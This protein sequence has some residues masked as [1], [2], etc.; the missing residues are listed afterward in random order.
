M[1]NVL[2]TLGNLDALLFE[3]FEDNEVML[4]L[5]SPTFK[6][7][8]AKVIDKFISDIEKLGFSPNVLPLFNGMYYY[9]IKNWIET[10]GTENVLILSTE[11]LLQN[12]YKTMKEFES[13]FNL[14]DYF[15]EKMF[16]KAYGGE[17]YC[18]DSHEAAAPYT[19]GLNGNINTNVRRKI[20]K[21]MKAVYTLMVY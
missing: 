15:T 5:D 21:I 20:K 1:S 13:F 14:E 4:N 10:F 7:Y 11:N 17:F 19:K 6:A 12:P 9:Y 16:K 18:I 3:N 2:K 8:K